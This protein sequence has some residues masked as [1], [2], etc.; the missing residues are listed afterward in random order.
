MKKQKNGRHSR[1]GLLKKTLKRCSV[2]GGKVRKLNR[3]KE[4]SGDAIDEPVVDKFIDEE[5]P[6]NADDAYVVHPSD[7]DIQ[8][9]LHN[10]DGFKDWSQESRG[11][12]LT[13]GDY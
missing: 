9:V 11:N 7:N 12:G 3:L 10:L 1:P 4:K 6:I 2:K 5:T 13:Y 8:D